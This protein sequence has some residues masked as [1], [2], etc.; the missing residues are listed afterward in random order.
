MAD[1]LK[2][3]TAEQLRDAVAWA[4]GE[5]EP[6]EVVGLG[7]KRAYGR[8]MQT[9]HTL[10]L[11]GLSGIT[12][13]EPDELVLS[14][15]AGTPLAEVRHELAEHGQHLAF[16]PPD[17]APLYGG[18][19]GAGTI[20]GLVAANLAGPRRLSAGAVR[21]YFLGFS[22][23]SGR[24]ET[25]KSGGRVMKNVTGYDLSKL[26]CGS[27]GTLAAMSEVTLK[28]L[29]APEKTRTVLVFG[30]DDAAATTAMTRAMGAS[31][32]V[33]GA[34]HL[35]AAVAALAEVSHVS[36]AGGPVTA[37]RVEG[38]G[39]SVAYR[40]EKLRDL[41]A[42]L[43]PSEE[44]HS[45]NSAALWRWV[46][47]LQPFV[48][49]PELAV[50]RVSVAPQAGHAVATAVLAR[51]PEALYYFDWAGGLVWFGTA[52]TGDAGS[53][54]IRSAL[55]EIGGGHATLVRAPEELRGR[56]EVF[57][58]LDAAKRSLAARLKE[59]F[60]PRRILNPGRMYAGG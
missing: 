58:P 48:D 25:F 40:C 6:L 10:D 60:D 1:T 31:Y 23:V 52:A 29:P 33:S 35:P 55:T 5:E 30:L 7:S 45:H 17:L 32:E 41:L 44:L 4:S 21:D 54:A 51:L 36:D 8:P 50:W 20:G 56:L 24:G 14:A 28:V 3:E 18:L 57:Q 59:G 2:P 37:V 22:G 26:L 13:Y 19:H 15:R 12:L 42:D 47:D 49:R 27:F 9:A 16:E 46:G 34:A 38:F 43:G 39:P 11:S 53:A